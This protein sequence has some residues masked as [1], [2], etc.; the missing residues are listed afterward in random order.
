MVLQKWFH[1][2]V[3]SFLKDTLVLGNADNTKVRHE[4]KVQTKERRDSLRRRGG[5][6]LHKKRSIISSK[7]SWMKIFINVVPRLTQRGEQYLHRL[8]VPRTGKEEM[9]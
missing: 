7:C 4:K 5:G 8:H 3:L 6:S 1:N 9:G 2:S